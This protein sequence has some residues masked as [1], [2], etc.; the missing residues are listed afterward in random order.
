M[1]SVGEDIKAD[2]ANWT[3][4]GKIADTFDDHV[5]K[6][7]PM[8]HE[9]HNISVQLADFFLANGSTCY[10]LGCSTAELTRKLAERNKS[11]DVRF[12][13]VDTVPEMVKKAR[14]K[15]SDFQSVT[16]QQDDALTVEMSEADCIL[17]YYTMQ[18]IR[19]RWR[20]DVINRIYE[21][22]NWGGGF[23]MFEKVRGPDARF[24][25]MMTA[26][27]TEHKISQ[28]YTSDEIVNKTRSLKG[29]LE[30]FS[31]QGNIDMLQRAGFKDVVS[32]FKWVCF[33]GFLA[34]K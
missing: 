25:D 3:F 6:S 29:V 7:V 30:P 34:I 28:D 5:S 17:A 31:T 33:E 2:N 26:I 11:K 32:V 18:F 16:I 22:L 27:Y 10:E 14:Q 20:Q 19:P 21:S 24:Q 1:G 12:V 8:Y 15:C 13:G 9:G 23:I 4:D